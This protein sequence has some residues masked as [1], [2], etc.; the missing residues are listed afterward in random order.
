M[1]NIA[2]R[3]EHTNNPITA[4][5]KLYINQPLTKEEKGERKDALKCI[6]LIVLLM[7]LIKGSVAL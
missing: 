6:I 3:F 2:K 4:L 1:I 7:I 5:Y